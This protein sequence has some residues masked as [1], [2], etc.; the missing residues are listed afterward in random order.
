MQGENAFLS[1]WF[2]ALNLSWPCDL[3]W[4]TNRMQGEEHYETSEQCLNRHWSCFYYPLGNPPWNH[5]VKTLI[6]LLYSMRVT[7]G[8]SWYPSLH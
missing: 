1:K 4:L 5:Q 6:S 7:R 8:H 3:P 2:I